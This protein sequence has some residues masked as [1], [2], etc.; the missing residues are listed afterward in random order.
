MSKPL[1]TEAYSKEFNKSTTTATDTRAQKVKDETADAIKQVTATTAALFTSGTGFK[2]IVQ[3][4]FFISLGALILFILLMILHYAGIPVFSFTPN[5]PGL[6]RLP[7]AENKQVCNTK[8]PAVYNATYAFTNLLPY[9]V[10]FGLDVFIKSEF[11]TT[12]PRVIWYR[13]NGYVSLEN[14]A[15]ES[16]LPALFPNSNMVLYLDPLKNDLKILLQGMTGKTVTDTCV[17]NVPIGKSF[18]IHFALTS[19]TVEVYFSGQLVKTVTIKEKLLNTTAES[20]VFGPP[21]IVTSV[22]VANAM[23]WP[24]LISPTIIL[25]SGTEV[26]NPSI[27]V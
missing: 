13:A 12:V 10:T 9:G 18:R 14:T 23:Y 20:N 24:Y 26:I 7:T 6:I 5:D 27:F 3:W 25:V 17:E 8:T 2:T 15:Q 4:M 1:R 19:Q 21:N 11:T 16:D 22:K